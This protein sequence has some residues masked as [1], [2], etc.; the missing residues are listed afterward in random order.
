[1]MIENTA[2]G[3]GTMA[4]SLD[5]IG[6]LWDAVTDA[7]GDDAANMGFC[8]DTCHANPWKVAWTGPRSPAAACR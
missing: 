4:R 3:D 6:R 8:L 1:M 7:A 5:P 2:G